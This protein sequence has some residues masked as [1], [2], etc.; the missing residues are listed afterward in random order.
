[1]EQPTIQQALQCFGDDLVRL[2]AALHEVNPGQEE[3]V[4]KALVGLLN[5]PGSPINPGRKRNDTRRSNNS[6]QG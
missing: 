2:R 6:S 5:G 3:E 4:D 1:M